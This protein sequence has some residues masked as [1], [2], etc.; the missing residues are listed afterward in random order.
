MQVDDYN[1][2]KWSVWCRTNRNGQES[3]HKN[4]LTMV[5]MLLPTQQ[6]FHH[7][8]RCTSNTSEHLLVVW[9]TQHSIVWFMGLHIWQLF[10]Y[11]WLNFFFRSFV[12]NVIAQNAEFQKI[13]PVKALVLIFSTLCELS[14]DFKTKGK[15]WKKTSWKSHFRKGK[16]TNCTNS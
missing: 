6:T 7:L 16:K 13:A 11:T 14:G 9:T 1:V 8:H 2:R 4:I 3:A 5:V 15:T 10:R 12:V